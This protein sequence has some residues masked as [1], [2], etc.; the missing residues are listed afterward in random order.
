MTT[1]KA[2]QL[3]T[4]NIP[5]HQGKPH[6]YRSLFQ[7]SPC[8][9][10]RPLADQGEQ[11]SQP[12][13]ETC[14]EPFNE[15]RPYF[16]KQ[17]SKPLGLEPAGWICPEHPSSSRVRSYKPMARGVEESHTP[18]APLTDAFL[19]CNSGFPQYLFLLRDDAEMCADSEFGDSPEV[20][21]KH[22]NVYARAETPKPEGK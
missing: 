19:V 5:S 12:D 22:V 16:R 13:C 14:K 11:V 21:I 10:W 18:Q 8:S 2:E 9:M 4:C 7:E 3:G 1:N 6:E 20:E 17:P 15:H